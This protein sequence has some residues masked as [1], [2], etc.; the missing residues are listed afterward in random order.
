MGYFSVSDPDPCGSVLKWLPGIRIQDSQNGVQKGRKNL[1]FKVEK[2]I[3]LSMKGRWFL[4]FT[5]AWESLL[6]VLIG[7][8]E[9]K[10]S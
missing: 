9:E 7:I 8:C 1:R 3:D 6:K 10:S 2:S 4:V 5:R